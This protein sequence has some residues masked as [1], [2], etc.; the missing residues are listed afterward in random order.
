MKNIY[1]DA[2]CKVLVLVVKDFLEEWGVVLGDP[3]GEQNS[4]N[5]YLVS[6]D[7]QDGELHIWA[8]RDGVSFERTDGA[9]VAY[10]AKNMLLGLDVVAQAVFSAL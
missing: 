5:L 10:G 3:S 6:F 1:G 2:T 9:N 8:D 7:L 4:E